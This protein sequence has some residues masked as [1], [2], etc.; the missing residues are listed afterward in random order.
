MKTGKKI[1]IVIAAILAVVIVVLLINH[2]AVRCVFYSNWDPLNELNVEGEWVGGATYAHVQYSDVSENDYLDLY[3]PDTP[4]PAPLI[5]LVHGGG[6]VLNDCQSRQAQLFYQY[7]RDHGYACATVNYRLAHEAKFPA[8][9][10]DVK[11]AIRFLRANA[12]TYGYSV[13]KVAIWGESAG[14]YLSMMAGVTNEDEFNDLPF[15]GEDALTE[16]VSAKVDVIVDFYGV[17]DMETKAERKQAFRELHIPGFIVD[18]SNMWL[19]NAVGDEAGTD[20]VEE[21]WTG[22]DLETA[23]QEE[24]QALQ[25][26]YYIEKNLSPDSTLHV[27]IRHGDADITVPVTQ[28]ERV[29]E[30]LC[31]K[32]GE[33]KVSFDILHNAKHAG[34]KLYTDEYLSGVQAELDALMQG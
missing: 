16:P 29:Y 20:N 13:D 32:L 11:A 28:S 6:F 3:V 1:L 5:V 8:A 14:G 33:D 31:D 17:M 21:Y 7:F 15:I 9:V 24:K 25:P 34:E 18:L 23:S 30:L 4:E 22:L 12:G 26:T 19:S 2:E 10:Q 27:I